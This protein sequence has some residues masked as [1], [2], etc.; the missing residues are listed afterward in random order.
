MSQRS[1]VRAFYGVMGVLLLIP[2]VAGLVGAFGGISG[3]S[4]LFGAAPEHS[5]HPVISNNFHAV[6][7][8][9]F[10]WVPLLV[11][12]LQSLA[13]RAAVF[14]IIVGC[15]FLTG[16]A[17]LTGWLVE[18]YPGAIPAILMGL[19]LTGMPALLLWHG[20]LVRLARQ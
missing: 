14:R 1:E 5:V 17:R 16:F 9:F 11:W 6:C 7:F 4:Q 20:R 8:A 10:S 12:S 2:A 15:A 3:M 13:D 18:G 19:E